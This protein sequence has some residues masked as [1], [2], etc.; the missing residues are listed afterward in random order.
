MSEKLAIVV[1]YR[2]RAEHLAIFEKAM[3]AYDYGVDFHIYIVEQHGNGKFNR[4]KLCNVG[5]LEAE[6]LGFTHVIFHD[7]D[8]IPHGVDYSP[9][10]NVT[11]LAA[12]ATQFKK[13]LPYPKYLG[14]VV[15][16]EREA[17]RKV[18]GFANDFWGWGLEDDDLYCRCAAAKVPI[19][20]RRQEAAWHESLSHEKADGPTESS[21]A[22]FNR[23]AQG[24]VAHCSYQVCRAYHGDRITRLVVNVDTASEK[25]A[26][27]EA[28]QGV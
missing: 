17:F 6:K 28:S 1:P 10:P 15:M 12:R 8:M 16:F 4:G 3:L 26:T 18:G 25:C 19:T 22:L 9:A 24:G 23:G 14:G 21:V 11:H 5:F 27:L 13:E 20:W 2:D 7:V